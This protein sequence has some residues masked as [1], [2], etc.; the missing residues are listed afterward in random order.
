MVLIT[1]GERQAHGDARSRA[2]IP[3]HDAEY[4]LFKA[5]RDFMAL[6]DQGVRH[7]PSRS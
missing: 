7:F 5:L 3:L 1:F 2:V 4:N 6:A